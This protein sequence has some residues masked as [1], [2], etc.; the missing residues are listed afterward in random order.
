MKRSASN[1]FNN[2]PVLKMGSV[3]FR[4]VFQQINREE[5]IKQSLVCVRLKF[6][7]WK[8]QKAVIS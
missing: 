8:K 6:D 4:R 1:V 5:N 2:D 7:N 3:V